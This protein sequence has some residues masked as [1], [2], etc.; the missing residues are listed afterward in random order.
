MRGN[1]P[2]FFLGNSQ[3]FTGLYFKLESRAIDYMLWQLKADKPRLNRLVSW[4]WIDQ[5]LAQFVDV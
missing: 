4:K 5:S 2:P 1:P 3:A